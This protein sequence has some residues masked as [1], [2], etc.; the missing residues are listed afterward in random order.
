MAAFRVFVSLRKSGIL[1]SVM[2]LVCFRISKLVQRDFQKQ[3][4]QPSGHL[5]WFLQL[6]LT[7]YLKTK[8]FLC[9]SPCWRSGWCGGSGS[10]RGLLGAFSLAQSHRWGGE[11]LAQECE[12][13]ALRA[14]PG[15]DWEPKPTSVLLTSEHYDLLLCC[16]ALL[17]ESSP[18]QTT[19][20]FY[21]HCCH[22]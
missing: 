10:N 4:L 17:I 11:T 1:H 6:N 14:K 13:P 5:P 12:W 3:K 19:N 9:S 18:S 20:S 16:C 21:R 8:R 7:G 2:L 22:A 15:A